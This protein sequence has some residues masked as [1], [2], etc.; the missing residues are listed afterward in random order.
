MD[1]SVEPTYEELEL[2]M[3]HVGR[4]A[5]QKWGKTYKTFMDDLSASMAK[6]AASRASKI[7]SRT[8]G[9]SR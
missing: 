6:A 7:K 8:A 3:K 4:S 1:P 9:L 5:E 2:L